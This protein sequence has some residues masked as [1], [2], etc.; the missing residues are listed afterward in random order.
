MLTKIYF[1]H[2]EW[3]GPCKQF[4]PIFNEV[5]NSEEFKNIEFIDVDVDND[6]NLI[7]EKFKVRNIPTTILVDENN[8]EIAKFVG[9]TTKEN[10]TNFLKE[11]MN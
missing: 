11:N 1:C 2:A 5:K 6:E 8:E 10:F 9:S 4:T 7:C 3:C